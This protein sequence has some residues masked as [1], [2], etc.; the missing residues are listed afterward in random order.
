MPIDYKKYPENWFTEIRPRIL[1]RANNCCE[2]CGLVNGSFVHSFKENGKTI[3]KYLQTPI[4]W[5]EK[6]KPKGVIVVLTIAHLDH[7]E[8]NLEVKDDRLKAMCQLHHLQYDVEE[9]KRRKA[10]KQIISKINI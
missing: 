8:G 2:V 6:G 7:D 5:E 9:K 10:E 3:W 1:K 4:E